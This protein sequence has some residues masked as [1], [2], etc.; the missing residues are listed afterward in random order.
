MS[1]L[2]VKFVDLPHVEPIVD[3]EK[4]RLLDDYH[5]EING[6]R[7]TVPAGFV[8]DGASIPRFLWRVCGHPMTARRFP[9]AVFHDYAYTGALGLTR[10]LADEI[11]S[12][13]LVALGFP[14][15]KAK[16]EYYA[17]RLFG[18]SHWKGE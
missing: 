11:Y 10:Q 12:A 2:Q 13:G 3:E 6:M 1:D 14:A 4:W 8:T 15:W 17:L 9:I 18:G 7:F 5:V 16:L